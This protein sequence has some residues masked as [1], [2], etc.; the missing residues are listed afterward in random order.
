MRLLQPYACP[1]RAQPLRR[2]LRSL[3]SAPRSAWPY[4]Q[5]PVP[6]QFAGTVSLSSLKKK[7]Q[8]QPYLPGIVRNSVHFIS[9]ESPVLRRK[10]QVRPRPKYVIRKDHLVARRNQ[11]R[12]LPKAKSTA[13]P[14]RVA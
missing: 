4:T 14:F 10:Q 8:R 12:G 6:T 9:P 3:E 13:D 5:R 1:V 7:S 2:S 11:Q